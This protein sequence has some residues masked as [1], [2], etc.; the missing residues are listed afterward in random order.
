MSRTLW[1]ADPSRFEAGELTDEH[2]SSERIGL[3]RLAFATL[4]KP[5]P[6]A[7]RWGHAWILLAAEEFIEVAEEYGLAFAAPK[8]AIVN[9]PYPSPREEP[10]TPC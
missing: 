10:S 2:R 5:Q 7:C 8:S 6:L 3:A 1:T 4:A 9:V